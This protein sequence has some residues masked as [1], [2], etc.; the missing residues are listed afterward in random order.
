[1][2]RLIWGCL[3]ESAA[4][5]IIDLAFKRHADEL[6]DSWQGRLLT[7]SIMV[8]DGVARPRDVI[9]MCVISLLHHNFD[10]AMPVMLALHNARGWG[11]PYLVSAAKIAKNGAVMAD[12]VNNRGFKFKNQSVFVDERAMEGAFRKIADELKFDDSDRIAMFDAV[13]RWIVCDY[14]L[15]PTMDSRDPEAKRLTVH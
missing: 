4:D 15:D 7:R 9:G 14:R 8:W 10:E 6:R 11:A 3:V 2:P 13:K 1:M 12:F 5:P